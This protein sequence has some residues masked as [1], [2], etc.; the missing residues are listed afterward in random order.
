MIKYP[1]IE[2]IN[3]QKEIQ[4]L[5]EL[6]KYKLNLPA[7]YEGN[8]MNSN[9]RPW[10]GPDGENGEEYRVRG[11]ICV[12]TP[13]EAGI[14]NHGV[15]ILYQLIN[16]CR[17]YYVE[18]SYMPE[19]RLYK[20]LIKEGLPV[21]F[22]Y[23]TKRP[24]MDFDWLGFS[25]YFELQFFNII[26]I[27]HKSGIPVY[28]SERTGNEYPLITMGG[29]SAYC[30][31]PI[32]DIMD[33]V[34]IGDGEEQL[35]DMQEYIY[36]YKTGKRTKE[37]TLLLMTQNI[38]GCYVP[39]FYEY[40]F[41]NTDGSIFDESLG[42]VGNNDGNGLFIQEIRVKKQY[43]GSVKPV[44]TKALYDITKR[45][46]F[47]K[48][49]L[50]SMEANM[51]GYT[52]VEISR[53]CHNSCRFCMASAA[54]KPYREHPID[55]VMDSMRD[56]ACYLGS[57]NILPY[58]LNYSSYAQKNLLAQ[59]LTEETSKGVA[60]STQRID[61]FSKIVSE[62][63]VKR[64]IRGATFALEAGSQRMRDVINKEITNE[65]II[66][67][68]KTV[69]EQG[70]SR[71]KLYMISNLPFETKEDRWAIIDLL[72]PIH[73]Y[74]KELE[75][76]IKIRVSYTEFNAKP[77]TAFQWADTSTKED[78]LTEE[79]VYNALS[80]LEIV[81]QRSISDINNLL[82]CFL[83]RVDR[84]FCD[85][86][87]DATINYG[88]MY[89]D[90]VIM[91]GKDM[92]GFVED[93]IHEYI[94]PELFMSD[95]LSEK[96]TD[97]IFPWDNLS[98]GI[99]KEFL[100]QEWE[101]AKK[102]AITPSCMHKCSK[103]G[104]CQNKEMK[105]QGAKIPVYHKKLVDIPDNELAETIMQVEPERFYNKVVCILNISPNY[106]FYPQSKLK[107]MLKSAFQVAGYNIREN[108]ELLSQVCQFDNWVYGKDIAIVRTTEPLRN[109][110]TRKD[111]AKLNERFNNNLKVEKVF[112][113][114]N[115]DVSSVKS[116]FEYVVYTTKVSMD[117][118]CL[119]KFSIEDTTLKIRQ[120][121]RGNRQERIVYED[122]DAYVRYLW[123]DKITDGYARITMVIP[124]EINP[125]DLLKAHLDLKNKRDV[126]RYPIERRY[127]INIPK[128]ESVLYGLCECGNILEV[129]E[130]NKPLGKKCLR[131]LVKNGES[132][133]AQI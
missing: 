104:A 19:D 29:I 35:I 47:F 109:D 40:I 113:V 120:K 103:C 124:A 28:S 89:L 50:P 43:V 41:K 18:R 78:F 117:T 128:S 24:F 119:E 82:M 37:E 20:N 65:Q 107:L 26:D 88:V 71:L 125:Y 52:S 132:K 62:A 6:N 91:K 51:L 98:T 86:L 64:G 95:W 75:S 44:I 105:D 130:M 34:F 67:V 112:V 79:G 126:L 133:L 3:A 94:N 122:M 11:V 63:L 61:T 33:V 56:A 1:K 74:R 115:D 21:G 127:A 45:P 92:E 58:S 32:A 87:V 102:A 106:R 84:R 93:L 17:D 60:T 54:H 100:I 85:A 10:H 68:L 77:F 15:A 73:E 90:R 23:E 121:Q 14:N 111:I 13:Y 5:I 118:S 97:T 2:V 9:V 72:R 96:P 4:K 80:E 39:S 25:T 55:T 101:N 8:E 22:G 30:C 49:M 38:P 31:E 131:C 83:N 114:G 110:F 76:K 116:L 70:Y 129:D 59:K 42:K 66:D 57:K 81:Y 7:V 16:E 27:L 99:D 12:P 69:I 46:P 36:D 123:A 53:G 108:I 48:G